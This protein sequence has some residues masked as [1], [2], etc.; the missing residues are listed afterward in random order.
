M[1]TQYMLDTDTCI[2][3]TRKRSRAAIARLEYEMEQGS[4]LISSVTLSELACGVFKS[5]DPDRNRLAL[6]M[7][8]TGLEVVPY[9]EPA[10]WKYGK[11]RAHLERLG[12]PI[13]SEDLFIAA[14]SLSCGTTLVTSN[15]KHFSKVPDLPITSWR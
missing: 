9:D 10:G 14:H 4:V 15:H 11:I 2:D 12:T 7:F 3:I 13:G 1:T 5:C 6:L 8:L